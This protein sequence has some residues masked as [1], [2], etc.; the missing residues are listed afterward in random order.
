MSRVG[1]R[2]DDLF[3]RVVTE[4]LCQGGVGGQTLPLDRCSIDSLRR[5]IENIAILRFGL[6][7]SLLRPFAFRDVLGKY[8]HAD[9]AAV[10]RN[11]I[12]QHLQG[13][14]VGQ[15]ILGPEGTFRQSPLIYS[16]P[17]R[18]PLGRK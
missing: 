1:D 16:R 5:P 11:W 2:G 3:R 8:R 15:G 9:S 7:K 17:L 12:D 6:Q 18:R 10:V 4:N 13:S 14:T